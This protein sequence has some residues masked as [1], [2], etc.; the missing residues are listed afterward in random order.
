MTDESTRRPRLIL[1]DGHAL[2]YRA[3][4]ALSESQ[5]STSSGELTGGIFG[6]IQMLLVVLREHTPD[7]IT[8]TWDAGLSGRREEFAEYKTNRVAMPSDLGRQIGRIREVLD[9]FRAR[10]ALS[11]ELVET[12]QENVEFKV[13]RVLREVV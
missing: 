1:I 5:L 3:F 7:Y 11:V 9:A 2:A 8:V 12:A 6:F 10:F 4:H 13:P